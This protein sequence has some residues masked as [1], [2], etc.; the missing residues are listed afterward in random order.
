[1][2]KQYILFKI[3]LSGKPVSSTAACI[4]H[5]YGN[6]PDPKMIWYTNSKRKVNGECMICTGNSGIAQKVFILAAFCDD[7]NLFSVPD[8]EELSDVGLNK[9]IH[10]SEF[11]H[12]PNH[13]YSELCHQFQHLFPCIHTELSPKLV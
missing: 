10:Y 13:C 3:I 4:K 5:G 11:A 9:T 12:T 2:N 6:D 8:R 1:M 7:A